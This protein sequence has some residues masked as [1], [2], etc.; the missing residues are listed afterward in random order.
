M[1]IL[2]HLE[3][4][5]IDLPKL[6]SSNLMEIVTIPVGQVD[7]SYFYMHYPTKAWL[8]EKMIFELV[9]FT[10]ILLKQ[11]ISLKKMMVLS[12]KFHFNLMVSYLYSFNPFISIN[13]IGK[14]LSR[15]IV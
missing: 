7:E 9:I 15:S 2:P 5:R 10:C 1:I 13:E 6:N 11:I 3:L 4:S 8:F 14:Y 12:V